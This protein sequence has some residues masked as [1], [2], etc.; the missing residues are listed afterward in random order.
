MAPLPSTPNI[1]DLALSSLELDSRSSSP[2]DLPSYL[3]ALP[4]SEREALTNPLSSSSHILKRD[5]GSLTRRDP[6]Q[7]TR[8]IDPASGSIDPN[9]INMKGIQAIFALIGVSF[10]LGAIWFF[11]WAKNGGFKWQKNDWDEYKS[12]VLRRK[13]PNGTTLS[14]A[15]K[16][17]VLGGGS[18]VGDGYSDR[19]D[20]TVGETMTE[21]SSQAPIIKE[22][23]KSNK[24]ETVK[25][26]KLREAQAAQYEGAND[27]DVRAYRHEKPAKVGGLNT[28]S[29]SQYYGTEYTQS[30]PSVM[31]SNTTPS[32]HAQ[33]S[34]PKPSSRQASRQSSRQASPDKHQRSSRRD[35]SYGQ[36]TA[37]NTETPQFAQPQR[38]PRYHSPS[39]GPSG[40]R[41]ARQSVP[42]SY[43]EPLDFSDVQSQ[44]TKSYHHPLPNVN[45]GA[46]AGGYRRDRRD[47]LE[48]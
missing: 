34:L 15:T 4:L 28:Q 43:A 12:T 11:F 2:I 9:D 22:K 10:V 27:H 19:D 14:N 6:A 8:S 24:K 36:D 35:F 30:D 41:S 48:D 37:F 13:G 23:R 46:R 29:D 45:S 25:D 38:P 33:T 1:L 20:T 32:V 47:S 26:R 3:N 18:V 31:Y 21:L 39:K 44:N 16:S 5:G 7:P 17:T 40:P 42:G